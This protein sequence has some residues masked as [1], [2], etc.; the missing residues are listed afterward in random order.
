MN[1]TVH[2]LARIAWNPSSTLLIYSTS[3]VA[4]CI[5]EDPVAYHTTAYEDTVV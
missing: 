4:V 5:R 2:P 1:T 3:W